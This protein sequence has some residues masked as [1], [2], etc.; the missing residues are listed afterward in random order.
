MSQAKKDLVKKLGEPQQRKRIT[1]KDW[2][3]KVI[4]ESEKPSDTQPKPHRK[5][6]PRKP[7]PRKRRV[8]CVEPV[9]RRKAGPSKS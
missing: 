6:E 9:A 8:V 1:Y 3:E 4:L 7:G 2:M 5:N